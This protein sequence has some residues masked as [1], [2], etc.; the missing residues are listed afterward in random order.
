MRL[1]RTTE[2]RGV[3]LLVVLSLLT[4]LAIVADT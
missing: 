3:I 1:N 2:R 4:L